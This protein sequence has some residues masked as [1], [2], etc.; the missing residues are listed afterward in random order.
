[1]YENGSERLDEAM[2]LNTLITHVRDMEVYFVEHFLNDIEKY[3]L[4]HHS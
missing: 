1:L 2:S 4:A 3:K